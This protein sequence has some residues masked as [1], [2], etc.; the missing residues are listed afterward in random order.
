MLIEIT[1]FMSSRVAMFRYKLNISRVTVTVLSNKRDEPIEVANVLFVNG[2]RYLG[3]RVGVNGICLHTR[4]VRLS[5][6]TRRLAHSPGG[7]VTKC[8]ACPGNNVPKSRR[9][10]LPRQTM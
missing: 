3:P 6:D 8:S 7:L 1:R 4:S 5:Y 2:G 10:V 9:D